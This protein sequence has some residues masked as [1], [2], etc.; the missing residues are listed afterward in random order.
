MTNVL[1]LNHKEFIE[2]LAEELKGVDEFKPPQWALFVKT[3]RHKERPP[4]E[5]DWWYV[6]AAAV[7]RSVYKLQPIGVQKLRTKYGGKKNRGYKPEHFYKGSGNIIRK[8]LQQSEKAG[9]VKKGQKGIH[10]GR[11]L[12]TKGK[13][14]LNKIALQ[15]DKK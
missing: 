15:M 2:K 3:G 6:R 7:L 5:T 11:L 13:G 4:A 8:I 12:T 10:K 14:I 9:F 1:N